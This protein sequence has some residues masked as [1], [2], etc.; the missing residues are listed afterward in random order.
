MRALGARGK[1][2][3]HSGFL[4]TMEHDPTCADGRLGLPEPVLSRLPGEALFARV[5][6]VEMDNP[7]NSLRS[8]YS[9][10]IPWI[11]SSTSLESCG[12]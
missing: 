1:E 10:R 8:T 7:F 4:A 9:V 12:S 3:A 5:R 2:A 11:L 6:R